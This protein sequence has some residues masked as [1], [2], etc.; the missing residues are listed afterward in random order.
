[1]VLSVTHDAV[2]NV[3]LYFA[4]S[5]YARTARRLS[6]QSTCLHAA[7]MVERVKLCARFAGHCVVVSCYARQCELFLACRT[8]EVTEANVLG[9]GVL[10]HVARENRDC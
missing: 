10:P 3:A 6:A 1:M 4:R 8:V 5:G 9:V 2:L 7:S